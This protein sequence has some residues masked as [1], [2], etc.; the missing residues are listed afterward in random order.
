[1]I[2]SST[3]RTVYR[4][5][6]KKGRDNGNLDFNF[7]CH[8]ISLR[9]PSSKTGYPAERRVALSLGQM[10][11]AETEISPGIQLPGDLGEVM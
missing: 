8:A 2:D 10:S 9:L 4:F 11:E 6:K 7:Q 3:I 1:M 5:K